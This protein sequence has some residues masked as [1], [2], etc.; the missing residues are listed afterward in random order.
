MFEVRQAACKIVHSF[1]LLINIPLHEYTPFVY[2]FPELVSLF[3]S[4]QFK[5]GVLGVQLF[6]THGTAAW[7]SLS[8]TLPEFT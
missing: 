5:S 8:I 1:L 2:P 4:V 7:I 6:A 3:S